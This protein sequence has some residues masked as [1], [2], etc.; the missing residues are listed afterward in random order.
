MVNLV[1]EEDTALLNMVP[2]FYTDPPLIPKFSID[3]NSITE[4]IRRKPD[5]I[6]ATIDIIELSEVMDFVTFICSRYYG[7]MSTGIEMIMGRSNYTPIDINCVKFLNREITVFIMMNT[8]LKDYFEL[9]ALNNGEASGETFYLEN[10]FKVIY[11]IAN[12]SD[13]KPTIFA[14]TKLITLYDSYQEYLETVLLDHIKRTI[15]KDGIVSSNITSMDNY[16]L[17]DHM[18]KLLEVSET[19]LMLYYLHGID[20]IESDKE[21]SPF[22]S[23]VIMKI[24]KIYKQESINA[25]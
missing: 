6:K 18:F 13:L 3:T 20:Y 14:D 5:K 11:D 24:C 19:P 17:E 21:A 25:K 7:D 10:H 4:F 8:M 16:K 1:Y 15:E 2:G 9:E 23:Y 22:N 12:N